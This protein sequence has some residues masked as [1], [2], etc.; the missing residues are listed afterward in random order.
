[1]ESNK[2]F[3]I[4]FI[5]LA[6]QLVIIMKCSIPGF[7]TFFNKLFHPGKMPVSQQSGLFCQMLGVFFFVSILSNF[8]KL[9][10]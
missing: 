7:I 5:I 10:R 4:L 2:L 3:V 8:I 9:I 1:M 6:I